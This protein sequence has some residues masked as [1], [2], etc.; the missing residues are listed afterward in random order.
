MTTATEASFVPSSSD[1]LLLDW[2]CGCLAETVAW[3]IHVAY[4]VAKDLWPHLGTEID[5]ASIALARA[6]S[7]QQ[8]S[9]LTNKLAAIAPILQEDTRDFSATAQYVLAVRLLVEEQALD[10]GRSPGTGKYGS[11][12]HPTKQ[13]VLDEADPDSEANNNTGSR[14]LTVNEVMANWNEFL[15]DTLPIKYRIRPSDLE[16][17][18]QEYL[19]IDG[20]NGSSSNLELIEINT[21]TTALLA[22]LA[23]GQGSL[24]EHTESTIPI[25]TVRHKDDIP[26]ATQILSEHFAESST[27]RIQ[28]VDEWTDLFSAVSQDSSS[29]KTIYVLPKTR[30][31]VQRLLGEMEGGGTVA[32]V[33]VVESSW[34]ALQWETLHVDPHHG[35][36]QNQLQLTAWVPP[37]RPELERQATMSPW[38]QGGACTS[39]PQLEE[40]LGLSYAAFE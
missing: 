15:L 14:P 7:E 23:S 17:A 19:P 10:Q 37:T 12:Y 39:L 9:W 29:W 26:L 38:C 13:V 6:T 5:E 16:A 2:D 18:I 32:R 11:L 8:T 20:G 22:S 24:Q 35:T 27:I 3:R 40:Q 36:N 33:H 31:T 25:V 21:A 34:L 30:R 1:W 28:A 4:Q